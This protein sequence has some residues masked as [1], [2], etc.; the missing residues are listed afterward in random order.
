MEK[1]SQIL[2]KLRIE[3]GLTQKEL[4]QKLSIS[5]STIIEYE[6]GKREVSTQNLIKYA[7]FFNVSADYLLGRASEP[8]NAINP[9]ISSVVSLSP[10][11]NEEFLLNGFRNLSKPTR[12][13]FLNVFINALKSENA[14]R[15]LIE[16]TPQK[17][18]QKYPTYINRPYSFFHIS[19]ERR[20]LTRSD[21]AIM[22]VI[23]TFS[24]MENGCT[25]SYDDFQRKLRVSRA[26]VARTLNYLKLCGKISQD[27][28]H[29]TSTSYRFNKTTEKACIRTYL[30]LYT[31]KFNIDG[32]KQ[33]LTKAEID[34]LSLMITQ[35]NYSDRGKTYRGSIRKIGQILSL[36]NN[37][38]QKT[39]SKL[40]KTG[41]I[42]QSGKDKGINGHKMSVYHINEKLI[43]QEEYEGCEACNSLTQNHKDNLED[44]IIAVPLSRSATDFFSDEQKL[45]NGFRSL[46]KS[47]Q[48]MLLRVLDN[49][50]KAESRA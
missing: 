25:Y 42:F 10:P 1:I 43:R 28:T 21:L 19:M 47:T 31:S 5:Q 50:V 29:K 35:S 32:K 38:V 22:G 3:S 7:D 44:T 20:K 49:A 11:S 13:M 40:L 26:T 12:K 17:T 46:S 27:K 34:V 45:L 37:T 18:I 2:K 39:I 24:D 23:Y 4:S 9:S 15:N 30:C 48:E 14:K 36:S 16:K 33:Y 6:K 41:I 8:H